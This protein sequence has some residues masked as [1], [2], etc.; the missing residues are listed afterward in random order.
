MVMQVLRFRSESS[1]VVQFKILFFGS[2]RL[3]NKL[4]VLNYFQKCL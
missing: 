2:K 3:T 1:L 4:V